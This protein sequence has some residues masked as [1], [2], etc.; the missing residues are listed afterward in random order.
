MT[1]YAVVIDDDL[2]FAR[3]IRLVSSG[4]DA[5]SVEGTQSYDPYGAYSK[6]YKSSFDITQLDPILLV[7]T[8]NGQP[9]P[10]HVCR[11]DALAERS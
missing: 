7:S 4:P 9:V 3:A 10:A 2:E 5:G 6:L 8:I 1:I 11:I